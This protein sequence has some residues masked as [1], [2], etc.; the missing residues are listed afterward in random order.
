LW[1]YIVHAYP[2]ND[3]RYDEPPEFMWWYWFILIEWTIFFWAWA[4]TQLVYWANSFGVSY[5]II[6]GALLFLVLLGVLHLLKVN[7]KKVAHQVKNFFKKILVWVAM[8][9][10]FWLGLGLMAYICFLL[11]QVFTYA[12]VWEPTLKKNEFFITVVLLYMGTIFHNFFFANYI[13]KDPKD[14]RYLKNRKFWYFALL[15]KLSITITVIT[16]AVLDVICR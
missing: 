12:P 5:S 14:P 13:C 2:E 8:R 11:L 16:A 3:P 6:T 4:L 10:L 15:L 7:I 1:F 9:V